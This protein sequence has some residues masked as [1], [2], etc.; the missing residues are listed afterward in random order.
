MTRP[1][2]ALIAT[3]FLAAPV[4]A[5]HDHDN[6]AAHVHGTATLEVAVDGG[7]LS[8]R[9]E[10]PL[11]NLLGFEH[12]PKTPQERAAAKALLAGLKQGDKLFT[13][14]PAAGCKLA[15]ARVESAALE[16]KSA[17]GHGDVDAEYRFTCAQ[18]ARLTGLDAAL[19]NAYPGL[20]RIDAAVVTGKG[21]RAFRLSKRLHFMG[22]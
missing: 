13:P 11:A 3:L 20:S 9:L 2:L 8:V 18:P 17:D 21:Q 19:F 5:G 4:H 10:S 12:A 6:H 22:W 16:G 7:I 1:R 14:T 15:E